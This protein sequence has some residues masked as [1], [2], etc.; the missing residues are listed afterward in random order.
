MDRLDTYCKLLEDIYGKSIVK[1][2]TTRNENN[3]TLKMNNVADNQKAKKNYDRKEGE[4]C[5]ICKDKFRNENNINF[6]K[7][8]LEFPGWIR[9]LNFSG[10]TPAKE[11]MI[12]GVEPPKLKVQINISFGLG[13][14]PIDDSGNLNFDQLRETYSGEEN[15]FNKIKKNQEQKNKLWDYLNLLFLKKLNIIKPKIYITDLCKCYD[16]TKKKEMWKECL[17]EYLIKEI[18]LINPTLI[19]FQ[20]GKS[21]KFVTRY[22]RSKGLIKSKPIILEETESYYPKLGEPDFYEEPYSKP[23]FDKF[24]F[25]GKDIYFFKIYHQAA[26]NLGYLNISDR[27]NYIKQNHEFIKK[28]ILKEVLNID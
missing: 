4:G 25:N 21:Y 22:L 16:H 12:I 3:F 6:F 24:S 10:T 8:N 18:E 5:K 14:Y 26:F 19:I 11:I 2:F 15:L 9:F 23:Y 17:T 1:S 7:R 28:K 27:N 20:G 13:Y